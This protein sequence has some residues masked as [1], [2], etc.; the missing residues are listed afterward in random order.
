M[1]WLIA[2][3]VMVGVASAGT[4]R[5]A[6]VVGS[7]E[8]NGDRPTLHYAQIDAGKFAD[9]LRELAP[10]VIGPWVRCSGAPIVGVEEELGVEL[11]ADGTYAVLGDNGNGGVIKRVGFAKTGTWGAG[12]ADLGISSAPNIGGGGPVTLEDSPRRLAIRV[13]YNPTYSI[14]AIAATN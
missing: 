2:L 13:G 12:D 14:Y 8:G 10:L 9:V 1:R 4:R 11:D 6:I 7:N 3:V 5:V